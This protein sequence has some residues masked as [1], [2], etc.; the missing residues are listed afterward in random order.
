MKK[1]FIFLSPF[2]Y[3]GYNFN[4]GKYEIGYDST[5]SILPWILIKVHS[6]LKEEEYN[7]LILYYAQP[8]CVYASYR[9]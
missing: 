8:Q 5:V 3:Y 1:Y 2:N 9:K 4:V 6:Y 7:L